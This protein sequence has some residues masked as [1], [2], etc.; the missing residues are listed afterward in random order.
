VSVR[1]D[2]PRWP[3]HGGT[4]DVFVHESFVKQ[5]GD[6][7]VARVG[8]AMRSWPVRP[9]GKVVRGGVYG[10]TT[11]RFDGRRDVGVRVFFVRIE[12]FNG[13]SNEL[14]RT[15]LFAPNGVML[16]AHVLIDADQG[17]YTGTG[18]P[19]AGR[20]DL[21]SVLAHELGHAYGRPR[22]ES[23]CPA[24]TDLHY[25]TMCV[26]YT[27]TD[28]KWRDTEPIDRAPMTAMYR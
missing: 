5:F 13:A 26:S 11:C 18:V 20:Y 9:A 7:G 25:P 28:T 15:C 2:E 12:Q 4:V 19:P 1:N 8:D 10:G 27:A 16:G 22:H 23:A 21:W 24:K 14:A 17:W 6:S 3:W